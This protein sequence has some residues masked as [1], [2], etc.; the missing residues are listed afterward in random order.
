ML[1]MYN[2]SVYIIFIF[3]KDSNVI[4]ARWQLVPKV[5]NDDPVPLNNDLLTQNQ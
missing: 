3:I 5:R 1:F 4:F 2:M